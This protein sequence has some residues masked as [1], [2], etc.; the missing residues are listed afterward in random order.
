MRS[1]VP[2]PPGGGGDILDRRK[3]FER[4][5]RKSGRDEEAE[6]AFIESKMELVRS[7]P[8]LTDEEKERELEKLQRLKPPP[9][10]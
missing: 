10:T 5:T 7:D 3:A 9:R 8:N 4:L 2:P 6:R 1:K